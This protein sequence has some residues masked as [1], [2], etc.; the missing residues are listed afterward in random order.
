MSV[1]AYK[2][3]AETITVEG[4]EHRLYLEYDR[5]LRFF[6]MLQDEGLRDEQKI[7]LGIEM[8][9][10]KELHLEINKK[11]DILNE[12]I[13]KI[14]EKEGEN[15]DYPL[16]RNGNPIIRNKKKKKK[17]ELFSF[18]H[19]AKYI[20]SAFVQTYGINLFEVQGEMSWWE[21]K[22]LLE[23]LPDDTLFNK[24]VDIRAKPLPEGKYNKEEREQLKKLKRRFALPGLGEI[25]EDE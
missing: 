20:F 25:K 5:V 6:E 17:K 22:A 7:S 23:G 18:E 16:D 9:I 13:G 4:V 11:A 12:I 8:I 10:Q 1:L 14:N 15:N 19:D 3:K 24:I 21:F 2:R